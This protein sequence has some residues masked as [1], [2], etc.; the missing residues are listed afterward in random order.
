MPPCAFCS[1]HCNRLG[2]YLLVGRE[3]RTL[4]RNQHKLIYTFFGWQIFLIFSLPD[5][6]DIVKEHFGNPSVDKIVVL[7]QSKQSFYHNPG[8][9]GF[10][11]GK[12]FFS[13]PLRDPRAKVFLC[14]R[15]F[16]ETVKLGVLGN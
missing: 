16:P 2:D 4:D 7:R 6:Q 11:L 10:D 5:I 13:P 14:S 1:I 8:I 9:L 3:P 12:P 15:L